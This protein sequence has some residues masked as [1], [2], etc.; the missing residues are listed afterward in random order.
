MKQ[1][2]VMTKALSDPNRVRILCALRGGELCVCQLVKLLQLAPSTVSKHLSLLQ[3]ADLTESR[4]EGRWVYYRVPHK[5]ASNTAMRMIKETF[6]ATED[7]AQ[8]IKDEKA[9]NRIRRCNL[10]KLCRRVLHKR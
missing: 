4:K 8:I 2:L 10:E 9:M 3:Q 6:Q 5:P 1:Y 7:S